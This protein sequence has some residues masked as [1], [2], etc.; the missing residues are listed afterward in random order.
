MPFVVIEAFW[1][2]HYLAFDSTSTRDAFLSAFNEAIYSHACNVVG[3]NSI[4]TTSTDEKL[5]MSS[6]SSPDN[7]LWEQESTLEENIRKWAF[8]SSSNKS[9]HRMILN[10]RKTPFDIIELKSFEFSSSTSPGNINNKVDIE[11]KIGMFVENMLSQALSF[12]S[13]K[14]MFDQYEEFIKFLNMTCQLRIIPL[15]C[16][17]LTGNDGCC[18]F[19]NIYHC[20]LQHALILTVPLHGPLTKVRYIIFLIIHVIISNTL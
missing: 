14:V 16:I 18:I 4:P 11:R 19:I 6:P 10:D 7:N 5:V 8:I 20:L 12:T 1:R 17:D 15:H 13:S 3:S 9:K 2:C